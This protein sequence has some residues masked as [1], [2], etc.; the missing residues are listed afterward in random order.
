MSADEPEEFD[1]IVI[2]SGFGGGVM[3]CR[4]AEAG[5]KVLVLER[6]KPYGPGQFPRTPLGSST[7]FWDPSEQLYGLFDIWSFKKFEAI[8]SSGLG[9]G[10]LVYAN[11][12]MR[13]PDTWFDD[14][15]WPLGAAELEVP[16]KSAERMLGVREFPWVDQ[17]PKSRGFRSAAAAAGLEAKPAPLA[18]A[19]GESRDRLGD[20][21]D[22]NGYLRVNR[23]TCV[24][25]GQCDVGCNTGSKNSVDHTY[26]R[27]AEQQPRTTIKTLHEVCTITALRNVKNGPPRYE[28]GAVEHVPPDP[29]HDRGRSAPVRKPVKFVAPCVVFAAGAL[30]STYLL[31]RNRTRLPLLSPRLGSRFCG[32]GDFLGFVRAGKGQVLDASQGP[33]I[34]S[35][36]ASGLNESSRDAQRYL[37]QDGGYPVLADWLG[38]VLGVKP[39]KRVA[40]VLGALALARFTDTS[41]SR[42]SANL[43]EAI[44][45]SRSSRSLLPLLGMGIDRAHGSMR[46]R[47]GLLEVDWDEA[48][49]SRVFGEIKKSMREMAKGMG[50]TFDDFLSTRLSRMITVHPLGGAPMAEDCDQGVVNTYGEVFNYPGLFVADGSVMPGPAG[51]NPSLTI[52]AL[53]ERFSERAVEYTAASQ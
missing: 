39:I 44:G 3:A 49:S 36:V 41:R 26:L 48:Y 43:S 32:N 38:E 33:V 21:I 22:R 29:L 25:C 2:G 24:L 10:S 19:F 9:G 28:V 23:T 34:T 15:V 1:A 35:Y 6:G 30:G 13:M 46:L 11:V 40:G 20:P 37:I 12:M 52:A 47:D 51:V 50:G 42:I 53:A 45:E 4:L 31:L 8:V 16:Y 5:R 27:R 7:N 17:V 14:Q 18:V